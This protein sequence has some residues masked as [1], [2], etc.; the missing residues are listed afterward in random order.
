MRIVSVSKDAAQAAKHRPP[1][2]LVTGTDESNGDLVTFT[3]TTALVK[4]MKITAPCAVP[5]ASSDVI[6]VEK[7]ASCG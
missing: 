7:E 5:V 4:A 6:K 2:W 3:A 1:L